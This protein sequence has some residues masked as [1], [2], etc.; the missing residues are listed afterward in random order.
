MPGEKTDVLILGCGLGGSTV[1]ARLAGQVRKHANI[2]AIE[3]RRNLQL[4]AAFQWG[5][6]GW[7]KPSEV[8]RS[9]RPL[10]RKGIDLVNHSLDKLIIQERIGLTNTGDHAHDHVT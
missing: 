7:R 4:P 10:V 1:A 3:R 8:Q 5:M 6:M 2:R 9:L